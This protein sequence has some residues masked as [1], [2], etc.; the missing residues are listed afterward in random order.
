LFFGNRLLEIDVGKKKDVF[1][2]NTAI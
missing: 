1:Q 2:K